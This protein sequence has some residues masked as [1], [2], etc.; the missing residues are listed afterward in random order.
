M[1]CD[2]IF[3]MKDVKIIKKGGKEEIIT[4]GYITEEA[5]EI[6]KGTFQ[7]INLSLKLFS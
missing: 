4:N 6:F 7:F 1:F 2:E 5:V 3:L